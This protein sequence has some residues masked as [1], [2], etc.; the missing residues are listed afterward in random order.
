MEAGSTDRESWPKTVDEAADLI[1]AEM[2]EEN[3]TLVR[4]TSRERLIRFHFTWGL[5]IRNAFGLWRG[6][7]EL[8]D[9]CGCSHADECS[10][11]I[12]ER[13]WDRLHQGEKESQP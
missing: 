9:S 2:S 1:L 5:G 10:T 8:L 13:V 4:E 11:R 7:H 3:K 6:N 12:M